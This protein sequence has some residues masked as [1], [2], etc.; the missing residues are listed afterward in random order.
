MAGFIAIFFIFA[1]QTGTRYVMNDWTNERIE[2]VMRNSL[3]RPVELGRTSWGLGLNGLIIAAD[4]IE[5]KDK[6]GVSPFIKSGPAQI[7][8][9]LLPMLAG[10]F[11]LR[12]LSMKDPEVWAVQLKRGL[13]NFSD[14]PQVPA[15]R[16]IALLDLA[17]ARMNVIDRSSSTPASWSPRVFSNATFHLERPFQKEN[18]PFALSFEMPHQKYKTSVYIAGVGNGAVDDWAKNSHQFRL[19]ARQINL[20]DFADIWPSLPAITGLLNIDLTGQGVPSTS[21][22]ASAVIKAPVLTIAAPGFAPITVHNG[23]TSGDF[24]F[25]QN[26]VKWSNLLVNL[27]NFSLQSNG[28][29]VNPRTKTPGYEAQVM[30]KTDDLNKVAKLLPAVLLPKQVLPPAMVASVKADRRHVITIEQALFPAKLTGSGTVSAR[31]TGVGS[32]SKLWATIDAQ[33][34]ALLRLAD[35]RPFQQFPILGI[36]T[37]NPAAKLDAHVTVLP[38][39]RVNINSGRI[40][41]DGSSILFNGYLVPEQDISHVS[42]YSH[43]LSLA[44][45]TAPFRNA[46]TRAKVNKLL[47]LPATAQ[48]NVQGGINLNGVASQR[49]LDQS[50]HVIAQLNHLNIGLNNGAVKINDITGRV[51]VNDNYIYLEQVAGKVG[52]GPFKVAGMIPALRSGPIDLLYQGSSIDMNA[53]R[54]AAEIFKFNPPLMANRF[55]RGRL[56][57]VS[58]S[59]KGTGTHPILIGSG[60]PQNFAFQPPNSSGVVVINSGTFHVADNQLFFQKVAGSIGHGVFTLQGTASAAESN[61]VFSGQNVDISDFRRAL[62]DLKVNAPLLTGPQIVF[63]KLRSGMRAVKTGRGANTYSLTAAPESVYYQPPRVPRTFVITGGLV[64]ADNH[65]VTMNSLSG[66]LGKGTFLINGVWQQTPHQSADVSLSGSNL[67]LSNI[68]TTLQ[69]LKVRSPLLAQQK[70]FGAINR[71]Q[72]SIKGSP[73]KP[74][75]SAVAFPRDIYLQPFG[76]GRTIHLIGGSVTYKNDQL[77]LN[78]TRLEN[79]RSKA[80]L[81]VAVDQLS[82]KSHVSE[83]H[84][85]TN[86]LDVGDISS[87]LTAARTPAEIRNRYQSLLTNSGIEKISGSL[88]GKVDFKRLSQNSAR[89]FTLKADLVLS[90]FSAIVRGLPVTNVSGRIQSVG[91]DLAVRNLTGVVGA[92]P[93]AFNGLI[94]TPDT[95]SRSWQGEMIAQLNLPDLLS[96]LKTKSNLAQSISAKNP[97]PLK[98]A[99]YGTPSRTAAFYSSTIAAGTD[100]RLNAPMGVLSQPAGTPVVLV[101]SLVVDGGRSPVMRF[102]DNRINIGE[103]ALTWKGDLTRP[104]ASLHTDPIIN[105]TVAL[106]HPVSSHSLL[107]LLPAPSLQPLL[108]GM[109]GNVGGEFTL[110]GPLSAPTSK[111]KLQLYD[112]SIPSLAITGISG[113]IEAPNGFSPLNPGATASLDG[114]S[115]AVLHIDALR[116]SKAVLTDIKGTISTEKTADGTRVNISDLSAAIFGGTVSVQGNI[117]MSP[118]RSYSL[119]VSVSDINVSTVML[120]LAGNAEDLKGTLSA[121]GDFSGLAGN[122]DEFIK[123]TRGGGHFA[124]KNGAVKSLGTLQSNLTRL[125]FLDQ[126]ILGFSINNLLSAIHPKNNGAFRSFTGDATVASGML[127]LADLLFDGEQLRMR[128]Q[129]VV[130]LI[131]GSTRVKVAGNIPR[132]PRFIKGPMGKL[133]QHLSIARLFDMVTH[134][135]FENMPDIPILGTLANHKRRAFELEFIGNIHD[136]NS[137]TQS[138]KKTF[139]WLPNQPKA[140]PHPVF[141]IAEQPDQAPL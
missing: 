42:F 82:G 53:I 83:L 93:F 1:V 38:E 124:I 47:G 90:R 137:F 109:T 130:D 108:Q 45:A 15:L 65:I 135:A 29:V 39:G 105:M 52:S 87:Y 134:G 100:L 126:G 118:D 34:I 6:D 66:T 112:V 4:S 3:H 76:S 89:Q 30:A 69:V 44:A 123:T 106:P 43:D 37:S 125:N 120:A 94:K 46:E 24:V 41:I 14:L 119:Q 23:V 84:L 140:T 114:V 31:V 128:G 129:G 51:H 115:E 13:W 58:L 57:D 75:I 141:G 36:L 81:S 59:L 122:K 77:V 26:I 136:P 16:N 103:T 18:W 5:I 98:V 85:A 28:Q 74:T 48:V 88:R 49:G 62:L 19:Q 55:L 32:A 67:D 127:T 73:T 138:A 54:A 97:I 86:G 7:G 35:L 12:S 131:S 11:E 50:T 60:R 117:M 102:F 107:A 22:T 10:A 132:N 113:T 95:T 27:G 139:H 96:H 110:S 20:S 70:L 56:L 116:L 17:G 9:P 21:F 8:V 78:Q 33:D 68:K 91:S 61:L 101:G 64:H 2:Q 63:G 111:G 71:V 80:A 79:G 40:R 133:L 104:D 121:D 92:S 99:I 72:L 25:S